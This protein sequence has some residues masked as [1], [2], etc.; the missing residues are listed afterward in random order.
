MQYAAIFKLNLEQANC[1][2][3]VQLLTLFGRLNPNNLNRTGRILKVSNHEI[4]MVKRIFRKGKRSNTRARTGLEDPMVEL[5]ARPVRRLLG[6][7]RYYVQHSPVA[8]QSFHS[9]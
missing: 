1:G 4:T 9:V 2:S 3:L 7:S 6:I 8:R 5:N